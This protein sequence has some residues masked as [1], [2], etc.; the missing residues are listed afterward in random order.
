MRD[1]HL[2]ICKTCTKERVRRYAD[3]AKVRER[4]RI[5][6]R[7]SHRLAARRE[8]QRINR[9]MV[10]AHKAVQCAL[11]SGKLMKPS[12]C[13]KCDRMRK[14]DA[15]HDDYAKPLEVRWLCRPCHRQHHACAEAS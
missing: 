6:S 13:S 12:A 3:S 1:G 2:N 11:K 15:H 14:L 9:Q 4:E 7:F 5:R 10:A 8:Y